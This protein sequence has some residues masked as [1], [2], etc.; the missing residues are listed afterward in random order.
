MISP[1]QHHSFRHPKPVFLLPFLHTVGA[2][3]LNTVVLLPLRWSPSALHIFSAYFSLTFPLSPIA[4][5][6]GFTLH[7]PKCPSLHLPYPSL[8]CLPSF[9]SSLSSLPLTATALHNSTQVQTVTQAFHQALTFSSFLLPPGFTTSGQMIALAV[10]TLSPLCTVSL[11]FPFQLFLC[12]WTALHFCSHFTLPYSSYPVSSSF[13]PIVFSC[14]FNKAPRFLCLQALLVIPDS[15][16][17]LLTTARLHLPS[18]ITR[19]ISFLTFIILLSI[20]TWDFFSHLFTTKN[21]SQV[22]LK[23]LYLRDQQQVTYV[24]GPPSFWR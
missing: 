1:S 14:C 20:S 12:F 11:H 16:A 7:T 10:V 15:P 13:L 8:P 24:P 9:P 2:H 19:S 18:G 6:P 21:L 22:A 17:S 23:H 4:E 5:N 3:L